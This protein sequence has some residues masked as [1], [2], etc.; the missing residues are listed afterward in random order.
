MNVS[1]TLCIYENFNE[2][3]QWIK[4]KPQLQWDLRNPGL[5]L[6]IATEFLYHL[7][8]VDPA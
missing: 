6:E 3:Q 8:E 5:T 4:I 7:R 1:N 2:I